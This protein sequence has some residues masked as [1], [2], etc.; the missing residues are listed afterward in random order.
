M[1]AKKLFGILLAGA[2]ALSAVAGLAACGGNEDPDDPDTPD[3]PT[4]EDTTQY[5]IVGKGRGDLADQGDNGFDLEKNNHA[6]EKDTTQTGNVFTITINL[7]EGD[8]FGI[9]HD[10]AWDGQMGIEIV[11]NEGKDAEDKQIFETGGGYD[12][13]NIKVAEGVNAKFKLTLTTNPLL[14]SHNKLTWEIVE[15]LTPLKPI[16]IK[17]YYVVGT[18]VDDEGKM[19]NFN[20]KDGVTPELTLENGKYVCTIEV[21]DVSDTVDGD[22]NYNWLKESSAVFACKVVSVTDE[23]TIKDWYNCADTED[24]ALFTEAGTYQ[25]V[26]DLEAGTFTFSAVT[27]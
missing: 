9:V 15:P 21:E 6:F 10:N 27:E 7:Y 2:M 23:D 12:I 8:E 16:V 11:E 18:F 14:P 17:G 20:Y 25:I 4:K 3:L 13:K 5:Y 1:K 26:F 24:N 22:A 19:V